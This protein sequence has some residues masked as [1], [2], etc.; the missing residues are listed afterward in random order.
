[1]CL[2]W[3]C[4]PGLFSFLF[5]YV[6]FIRLLVDCFCSMRLIYY[7]AQPKHRANAQHTSARTNSF[8]FLANIEHCSY[9]Y[10]NPPNEAQCVECDWGYYYPPDRLSCD[11]MCYSNS[12]TRQ[13]SWD[14]VCVVRTLLG[15][16][17]PQQS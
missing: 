4:V 3:L 17:N 2:V 8:L 11:R 9:G 14:S 5:V 16:Y 15:L 1:M 6:F 10:M 12:K 13:E 7:S